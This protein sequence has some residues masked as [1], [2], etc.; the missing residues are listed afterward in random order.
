MPN[1]PKIM[2]L[3]IELDFKKISKNTRH[4]VN[5][6]GGKLLVNT[7]NPYMDKLI[8]EISIESKIRGILW[9][10][11]KTWLFILCSKKD[12]RGDALNTIDIIS[13]CVKVG[14]GIDDN[15]FAAVID[16][17]VNPELAFARLDYWI[18]QADQDQIIDLT[19]K[20][21]KR[22]LE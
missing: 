10:K 19:V 11:C 2:H 17:S 16:Y 1:E 15:K 12:E 6:K 18:I 20:F 22:E 3:W 21:L 9:D 5:L 13:D 8:E 7:N 14:I 4:V